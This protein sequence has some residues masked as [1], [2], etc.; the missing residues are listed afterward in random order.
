MGLGQARRG[1]AG[2]G[3]AGLTW[4]RGTP[5]LRRRCPC[6]HQDRGDLIVA[7]SKVQFSVSGTMQEEL[8]Q[9]A[10]VQGISPSLVAQYVVERY[11]MLMRDPSLIDAWRQIDASERV[12]VRDPIVVAA[13]EQ[14]N[15]SEDAMAPTALR[16][17]GAT[18]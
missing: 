3:M 13:W 1:E 5:A 11:L 16:Q 17:R 6:H 18:R 15:G 8:E 4:G 10:R 12:I 7:C 9:R 2:L 14:I